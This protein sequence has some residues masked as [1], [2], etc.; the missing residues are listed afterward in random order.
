LPTF[1]NQSKSRRIVA[2]LAAV[3]RISFNTI[4]TSRQMRHAF[5]VRGCRLPDTE[6]NVRNLVMIFFYQLKSN[7][8]EKFK[9]KKWAG[10]F[11]S[12]TLDEYTSTRNRRY[13]NLNLHCDEEHSKEK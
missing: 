5:L 10:K 3:D 13:I 1:L 7:I 2:E 4:A 9:M 11:C 12:V 8:K 6:R